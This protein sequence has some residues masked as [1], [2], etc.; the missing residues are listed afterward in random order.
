[1]QLC[2]ILKWEAN[3]SS[4]M[5]PCGE[6]S[7]RSQRNLQMIHFT[8]NCSVLGIEVDMKPDTF[9]DLVSTLSWGA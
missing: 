2:V 9:R 5:S 4:K 8:I 1:M 6:G 7:L 3:C